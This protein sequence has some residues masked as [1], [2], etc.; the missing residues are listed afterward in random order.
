MLFG[1]E[2]KGMALRKWCHLCPFTEPFP[3]FLVPEMPVLVLE[4]KG[5]S[6]K[7][8]QTILGMN[9]TAFPSEVAIKNEMMDP[10]SLMSPTA[11][12]KDR[13]DRHGGRARDNH[14]VSAYGP[15]LVPWH[16]WLLYR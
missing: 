2:P 15:V 14:L 6:L 16:L 12:G 7:L 1:L 8:V 4:T 9:L 3:C 10:G 13:D 11:K 5:K